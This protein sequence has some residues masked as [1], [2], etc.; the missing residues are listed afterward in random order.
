MITTKPDD[1]QEL[2]LRIIQARKKID[3]E[4]DREIEKREV[5]PNFTKPIFFFNSF[6]SN[7]I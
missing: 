2:K 4:K 6:I 3:E 7:V 1:D 5:Q